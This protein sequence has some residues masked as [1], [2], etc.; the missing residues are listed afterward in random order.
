MIIYFLLLIVHFIAD[1]V[2]QT[3]D[4]ALNKSKS[5]GWLTIHTFVYWLAFF[6]FFACAQPWLHIP[7]L[8][9]YLIPLGI[10]LSH[11]IIDLHTSKLDAYLWEKKMRHWF[12]V[13]IGA[14]QL[15]HQLIILLVVIYGLN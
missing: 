14:D 3:D 10:G 7:E 2:C 12:F 15:L 6:G 5:L 13:S 8:K 11:W 1:F 4:M 9:V